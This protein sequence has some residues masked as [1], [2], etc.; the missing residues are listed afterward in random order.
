MPHSRRYD[1]RCYPQCHSVTTFAYYRRFFVTATAREVTWQPW[2]AMLTGMRDEYADSWDTS[3]LQ[4]LLEGPF[5]RTWYLKERFVRQTLGLPD[6]IVPAPPPT[7]MRTADSLPIEAI[8][9]FMVGQD[10]DLFRGVRDYIDF[11]R[12]HFMPS[13][14]RAHTADAAGVPATG[15]VVLAAELDAC[16]AA[17]AMHVAGLQEILT[18][19]TYWRPKGIAHHILVEYP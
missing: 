6:L 14:T 4:I 15:G 12:T 2:V 3:R 5:C 19:I 10:A 9:A 1:G 7:S 13:L 8:V 18:A 17:P 11:I 16:D